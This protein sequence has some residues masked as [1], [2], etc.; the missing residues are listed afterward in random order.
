MILT[1]YGDGPRVVPARE[2]PRMRIPLGKRAARD[3]A[4]SEIRAWARGR[5]AMVGG[6]LMSAACA[7]AG[8]SAGPPP[9]PPVVSQMG[10]GIGASNITWFP[11]SNQLVPSSL[12]GTQ[13]CPF[14][15][16]GRLGSQVISSSWTSVQPIGTSVIDGSSAGVAYEIQACADLLAASKTPAFLKYG[17]GGTT[18]SEWLNPGGRLSSAITFFGQQIDLYG[19]DYA[20][21]F[22]VFAFGAGNISS[23]TEANNFAED[24][25]TARATLDSF[26]GAS[27]PLVYY[28]DPDTETGSDP[29]I[30]AIIQGEKAGYAATPDTYMIDTAAWMSQPMGGSY[31]GLHFHTDYQQIFGAFV[32]ASVAGYMP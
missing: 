21:S 32:A 20:P 22:Y 5:Q 13:A 31:G 16:S 10:F 1:P 9:P 14:A 17:W 12:N 11:P 23:P 29:A 3:V 4:T 18:L 26:V 30:L 19:A 15:Y 27:L 28:Q 8:G 6:M 2:M 25:A 24:M 7:C